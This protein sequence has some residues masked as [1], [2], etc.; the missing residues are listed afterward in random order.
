MKRFG[1]RLCALLL[2]SVLSAGSAGF[3]ALAAAQTGG[4]SAEEAREYARTVLLPGFVGRSDVCPEI[5]GGYVL[6]D[7][8]ELYV[9]RTGADREYYDRVPDGWYFFADDRDGNHVFGFRVCKSEGGG[10]WF[11]GPWDAKGV[12]DAIALMKEMQKA[13]DFPE[14]VKLYAQGV[15]AHVVVGAFDQERVISVPSPQGLDGSYY[16]VSGYRQLPT[17]FELDEAIEANGKEAEKIMEENGGKVPYGGT[18]AVTA[19]AEGEQAAEPAQGLEPDP[20]AVAGGKYFDPA[21]AA[22]TAEA[23][24][25]ADEK[26]KSAEEQPG[27]AQDAVLTAAPSPAGGKDAS[28]AWLIAAAV[29]SAL[30]AG[31]AVAVALLRRKKRAAC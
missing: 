29:L 22:E 14:S 15:S 4:Q 28:S 17:R 26:L 24:P 16:E 31:S 12:S 2:V 6:G 20:E 21:L 11:I 9:Y 23:L 1:L 19:H 5:E 3:A 30:A 8:C 7:A 13:G 10:F 18:V 27:S 25:A